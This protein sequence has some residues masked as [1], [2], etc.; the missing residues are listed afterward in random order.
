MRVNET[1]AAPELRIETGAGAD[2]VN[3]SSAAEVIDTGEDADL[4]DPGPGEDA[5]ALGNGDDSVIQTTTGDSDRI[6]GQLGLDTLRVL[7]APETEEFTLQEL[8][9]RARNSRDASAAA[10]EL[11]RSRSRT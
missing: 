7:G 3:A 10:A 5:V 9:D 1:A 2:V 6:D 4:V 8:G 11:R